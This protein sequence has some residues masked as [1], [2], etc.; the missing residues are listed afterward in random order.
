MQLS[1]LSIGQLRHLLQEGH[2]SVSEI[3]D[4]CLQAIERD[5]GALNAFV[6]VFAEQALS[7]ARDLDG[8]LRAGRNRG[9]L[10]GIPVA[11]KDLA[12]V[13]GDPTGFGSKAYATG[14]A[15][16][17]AAF[18]ARLRAAGALVLG[19]TQM[20][21]FA[22]GS[23]GTNYALGSPVN[24]CDR[25]Q[26]RVAGGSSS[27]SAVAVAAGMVP[28]AI[29][30]DTGGSVRI[31]AS[32]CGLVGLK[33]SSGLV[34]TAG[35]APLSPTFDTIGP[36]THNVADAGLALDGLTGADRP[37]PKASLD[38]LKLAVLDDEQAEPLDDVVRERHRAAIQ[39]LRDAGCRLTPLRL[40][41]APL[42]V[43]ARN[44]GI[45]AYEAYAYLY[46]WVDDDSLPLDPCVRRRVLAGAQI[47]E[48][49]YTAMVEQRRRDIEAFQDVFSGFSALILPTTPK[50]PIPLEQV[51]ESTIP[52]SRLT[53]AANY[54]D[55][56]AVS[57]PLGG[58][59]SNLPSGLQISMRHGQDRDLLALATAVEDLLKT[60]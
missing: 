54:Y 45:M 40:P 5:D 6:S 33:T 9:P 21:E 53:R 36:L 55:L 1:A 17:D 38:G 4:S 35:V 18:V 58:G 28:F 57:L 23:W 16:A 39:R 34:S 25:R 10:H 42:E 48:Q 50:L 59:G 27:G 14:A 32:L 41:L 20:V 56:C 47:S 43:Q 37:L 11:V 8:E 49:D 2:V 52:M 30:S 26:D 7:A 51:D 24:P 12:D 60:G 29:G 46:P 19:K 13:A 31:P 22:F 3:V 15:K 44:G